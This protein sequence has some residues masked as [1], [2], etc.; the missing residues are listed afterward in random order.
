M[1]KK[2][3]EVCWYNTDESIGKVIEYCVGKM[4]IRGNGRPFGITQGE[5]FL[6]LKKIHRAGTLLASRDEW[7]GKN[8]AKNLEEIREGMELLAKHIHDMWD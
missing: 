8:D 1:S 2:Q 3:I 5:W 4:I 7:T 6:I